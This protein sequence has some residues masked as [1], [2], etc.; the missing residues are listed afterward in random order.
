MNQD[1][2]DLSPTSY[3]SITDDLIEKVTS[4]SDSRGF[5]SL[6]FAYEEAINE[7]CDELD[8]GL[9]INPWPASR[10]GL[11]KAKVNVRVSSDILNRMRKMAREQQTRPGT[12]FRVAL[13][14]WLSRHG[15]E[16]QD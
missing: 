5:T 16:Y 15:V 13:I 4:V 1:G 7:L 10:P 3:S 6:R 12:L 2:E 8:H 14:R 11:A 9:T